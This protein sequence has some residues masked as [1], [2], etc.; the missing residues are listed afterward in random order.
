[1]AV[2]PIS[3]LRR[4]DAAGFNFRVGDIGL[5]LKGAKTDALVTRLR[6]Q[7][8]HQAAFET[9]YRDSPDPWASATP[10]YHYQR[11]KYEVVASLL[12]TGGKVRRALDLGCGLGG[13]SRLLAD[14]ADSVLGL[15][16]AQSAIERARAAGIGRLSNI[17]FKQ[18]DVLALPQELDG[19]FDIVTVADVLY[20]LSPMSDDL[21]KQLATRIADLLA[22]GGICVLVNHFFFGGDADSKLSRRIHNA[23]EWSPRFAVV[24]THRR[25]FYL[26][27]LLSAVPRP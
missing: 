16:V 9:I 4:W 7:F 15:D 22:P 26:V 10:R 2:W 14:R 18:G 24:S 23:F 1:V 21:L 3:V 25:P 8:G 19:Q 17:E 11:R 27:S 12:P 20:Y 13:L 6:A 5:F